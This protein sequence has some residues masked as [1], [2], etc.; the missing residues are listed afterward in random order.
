MRQKSKG[1]ILEVAYKLFATSTY[2]GV[3][4]SDLEH[5]TGL[6]R[7]G[8]VHH[9]GKKESLFIDVFD[10]YMLSDSSM[11]KILESEKTPTLHE[12]IN[13]IINWIE[14]LKVESMKLGIENYNW[15]HVNLT[16][17]ARFHYP[18]FISKAQYWENTEIS[19]WKRIIVNSIKE[20]EIKSNLD[21]D[22]IS[23]MFHNLY[24]G[25]SY[26]GIISPKGIDAE[27]LKGS[28]WY[29]YSTIVK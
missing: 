9:I 21:I 3:T 27:K 2:E 25:Y 14:N 1:H 4:F 15:A 7:G 6:T 5:E 12:F 18:N 22:L 28:F 11:N 20:K 24:I 26:S 29:L 8:I 23:Y 17:Q 19:I 10:K 13:I 16:F